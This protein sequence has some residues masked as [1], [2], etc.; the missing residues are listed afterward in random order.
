MKDIFKMIIAL[1][2]LGF[3][4]GFVSLLGCFGAIFA[5]IGVYVISWAF[6]E[7]T[8]YLILAFSGDVESIKIVV[9][10]FFVIMGSWKIGELVW[11]IEKKLSTKD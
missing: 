3:Q 1:P 9:L 6:I 5:I 11:K 8:K 10:L 4:A 7:I 2:F